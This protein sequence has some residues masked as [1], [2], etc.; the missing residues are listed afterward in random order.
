MIKE[1]QILAIDPGTTKSG[2]IHATATEG[3]DPLAIHTAFSEI[4]NIELI[5]FLGNFK[6]CRISIEMVACYGMAVGREVFETCIW[7]GKFLREAKTA[8][9]PVRLVYRRE[10]KLLLCNSTKANDSNVRQALLDIYPGSGGGKV[11]QVGAKKEPGPLYGVSKH[12][13][14]ALGVATVAQHSWDELYEF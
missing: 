11:P 6:Q 12:A 10:V 2:M 1:Q 13:W 7:V 4:P 9:L 3:E 14:A 8:G 5:R